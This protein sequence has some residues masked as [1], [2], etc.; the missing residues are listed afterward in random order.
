MVTAAA[1]SVAA[2]AI[3]VVIVVCRW[4]Q[5]YLL[6]FRDSSLIDS[7]SLKDRLEVLLVVRRPT[8]VMCDK[9]YIINLRPM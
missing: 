6:N 7:K 9:T 3:L 1:D 5:R 8:I 4:V 2:F